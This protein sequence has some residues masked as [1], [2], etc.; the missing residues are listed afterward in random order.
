[1]GILTTVDLAIIAVFAALLLLY[2]VVRDWYGIREVP[3]RIDNQA[4]DMLREEGYFVQ[5]RAAVKFI[6]FAIE[7]RRHRQKVK[8]DLVVRRGLKKYVV[9]VNSKD[10]TSVRNADIRRRLLEYQIAFAPSG[11]L[12]VDVDTGRTKL[13]VINNRR[14]LVTMLALAVALALGAV[15]YLLAR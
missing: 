9:E 8:A 13:I 11:I 2:K 14:R 1:M 6:D 4:A 5:A 10:G 15:L 12:M 3:R 7:G